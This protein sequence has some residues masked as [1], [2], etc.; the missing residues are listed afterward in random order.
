MQRSSFLFFGTIR[1]NL[2][3]VTVFHL[4]Y[5]KVIV[6]YA[7]VI[8][9]IYAKIIVIYAKVIVFISWYDKTEFDCGYSFSFDLKF[10]RNDVQIKCKILNRFRVRLI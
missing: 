6:I 5:A 10:E 1:Q 9:F 7:K 3:V 4:I 2:I 8:V